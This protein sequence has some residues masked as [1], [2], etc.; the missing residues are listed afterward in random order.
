MEQWSGMVK[1]MPIDCASARRR[2]SSNPNERYVTDIVSGVCPIRA[3]PIQKWL[4]TSLA[5]SSPRTPFVAS[6]YHLIAPE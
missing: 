5:R 2:P 4:M 6:D 3:C 1:P